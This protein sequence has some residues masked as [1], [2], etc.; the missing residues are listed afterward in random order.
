VL[1]MS[2]QRPRVIAEPLGGS[3]MVRAGIAGRLTEWYTRRPASPDEWRERAAA[4]QESPAATGWLDQLGPAFAA[5]GAARERLER[6][7]RAGGV[8]VTTGQQPGLFGGPVYTLSKALSALELANAIEASTGIPVA[9]V[10][11][12]ATD[13]ADFAEATFTWLRQDG[14]AVRVAHDQTPTEGIPMAEVPLEG[15][16]EAG[17]EGRLEPRAAG[18]PE[19][20]ASFRELGTAVRDCLT[21]ASRERRLAVTLY[22]QGHTV[23]ETARILGWDNKRAENLVYRGLADLRQCL[24]GKGH[25]P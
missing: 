5:S 20:S 15:T 22:L 18:D 7:A 8:V 4:V 12:A 9:P 6:V 17:Q 24:L 16:P 23:P 19:S 3:A 11:W 13:D 2:E 10:F 25:R 21:A 14:G 1:S